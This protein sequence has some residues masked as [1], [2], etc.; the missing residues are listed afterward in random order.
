M[1]FKMLIEETL[2]TTVEVEAEDENDAIEKVRDMHFRGEIV[3][4]YENFS[5]DTEITVV[6]E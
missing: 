5:G 6:E 2:S 1:I 4:G 3:L